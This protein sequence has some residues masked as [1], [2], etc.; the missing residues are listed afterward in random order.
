MELI[1][2]YSDVSTLSSELCHRNVDEFLSAKESSFKYK[3]VVIFSKNTLVSHEKISE[4]VEYLEPNSPVSVRYTQGHT[5]K[6]SEALDEVKLAGLLSIESSEGD[7]LEIK[8]IH[9]QKA[10]QRPRR[11]KDALKAVFTSEGSSKLIDDSSLLKEED[12]IKSEVVVGDED[13]GP[14]AKKKACKNC[15]CG[16]KEVEEAE[17]EKVNTVKIIDTSNAKS[18]CGSVCEV[19]SI[20]TFLFIYFSFLVLLG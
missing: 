5:V 8:G 4:I 18:S 17:Q 19:T 14:K 6:L 2:A 16:L 11:S 20:I 10:M 3:S 7:T 15:S 9:T 13:C 1:L 12:L